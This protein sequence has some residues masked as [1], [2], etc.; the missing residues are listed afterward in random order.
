M[1]G[2]AQTAV[3]NCP[4]GMND[5]RKGAGNIARAIDQKGNPMGEACWVNKNNWTDATAW[6]MTIYGTQWGMKWCKYRDQINAVLDSPPG[7]ALGSDFLDNVDFYASDNKTEMEEPTHALWIK[8]RSVRPNGGYW[9]RFWRGGVSVWVEYSYD[10][11]GRDWYPK[12]AHSYGN[13]IYETNIPDRGTKQYLGRLGNGDRYLV[14]NPRY[15]ASCSST[16]DRN[17][18]IVSMSRGK[19]LSYRW[20]GV[21]RTNTSK[22]IVPGLHKNPGPSYPS[23]V[24]ADGRL[25]VG[26]S[27]NKQNIWISL[28]DVKDLPGGS[29]GYR[30]SVSAHE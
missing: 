28:V 7:V 29:Q 13:K 15:D 2:V 17:P 8:D 6:D 3:F 23:A 22:V 20:A 30:L 4:D 5:F 9:Q 1:W 25:I 16:C 12:S 24:E 14:H 21:V 11:W 19:D 18:L 10:L 26:Y 27:E